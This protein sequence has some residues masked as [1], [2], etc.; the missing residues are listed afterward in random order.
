[1]SLLPIQ[2]QTVQ[3]NA[4]SQ[5]F[6]RGQAYCQ[7]GAVAT[8]TQRGN[9][10]QSEV[11][12]SDVEPYHVTVQCDAT[13]ITTAYCTC[14]YSF[15]GWCKHIV[16]V[17]L[18]YIEQPDTVEVRPS[19]E[20]LLD[21]LD[22]GQTRQLLQSLVLAHPRLMESIDLQVSVITA[23]SSPPITAAPKAS[24][25]KRQTSVD[26]VPFRR[27]VRKVLRDAVNA[28]ESGYDDDPVTEELL[29]LIA[30]AKEFS[31][32][33]DGDAAIAVLQG[34]TQ[35][36][37]ED[38]D[39]VDEYG[40]DSYEIVGALDQ[41]WTEAIL[42]AELTMAQQA[43]LRSQFQDWQSWGDFEIS[44][45][46]LRQGWNYL[47][48]QQVLRGEITELGAWEGEPPHFADDLAA[49]RL[50]ILER[51]ERYLEYLHLAEAEGQTEQQLTMLARLGRVEEAMA[52]AATQ[53]GTV[54][55]AFALAETLRQQGAVESALEIA[56]VGLTL[57]GNLLALATWT[58]DLA[59]A[60][61]NRPVA[62]TAR[63]AAF[64][65]RPSFQD[66][67]AIAELAAERWAAQR[68]ELLQLLENTSG[69]GLEE[70]KVDI[71]L[72][73][74]LIANAIATIKDASYYHSPLIHRVMD[75]ALTEQPDWV[76]QNAR[77]RAEEIMDRGKADAYHHAIVWLQKAQA[78][79]R[80]S[81]RSLEWSAYHQQLMQTHARKYKL[82]AM[83]QRL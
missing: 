71:F 30:K 72:H 81:G 33:G 24:K 78:A 63:V 59:A 10:L 75:A 23:V 79:Y 28:W 65:A 40:A 17:L 56:Q 4:T 69:W 12:G 37:I 11:E 15:E 21:R 41:A 76:I 16:A 48:L 26:P 62:L 7:S 58:A 32:A 20:Q 38:W 39:Q 50:G 27:Q 31:Q 68:Q 36:C 80:Q 8:L 22:L 49:I 60:I 18:A 45:E 6:A 61:G 77:H 35:G 66:Y 54:G 44:R 73:E 83:L 47:P 55:E 34:I 2:L 74:G 3:R 25:T 13:H 51:Q 57:P 9:L 1:M 43:E 64:T 29:E 52:T 82:M 46:A 70:A 5:S 19:L 67:Q 14:P 53:M 42:T